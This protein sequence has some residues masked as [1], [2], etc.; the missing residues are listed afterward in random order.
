VPIFKK[1]MITSSTKKVSSSEFFF[2]NR[3]TT[4]KIKL[5]LTY[6]FKYRTAF[7]ALTY[8]EV[9]T[10]ERHSVSN[11]PCL[12]QEMCKARAEINLFFK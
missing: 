12:N 11:F 2:S 5:H 9:T 6:A 1:I 3:I 8:T 7:T 4:Y 10:A